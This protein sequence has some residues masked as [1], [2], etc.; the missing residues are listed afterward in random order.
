MESNAR[1]MTMLD[2][3]QPP[4]VPLDVLSTCA[5][6]QFGLTGKWSRL[7]GE[8]DLNYRIEDESGSRW[9]FRLCNANEDIA[10]F[11]CQVKALEHI[12][13]MDASLPVPK[14]RRTISNAL[15]GTVDHNGQ[16]Y[17]VI[18]LSFLAGA[19]IGTTRLPAETLYEVG[20]LIAR[21]GKALRGFSHGAP[22]SRHL[23]WDHRRLPDLLGHIDLLPA[24]EHGR[25]R[26]ILEGFCKDTLPQLDTLRNQ[27]IHSDAHP[28]NM[29]NDNG[30]VSGI[31]DFG[32]MV[33][34]TLVQDIANTIADFMFPGADNVQIIY[35]IVRGYNSITQLEEEE[36][37]LLLPVI[38]ARLLMT[39]LVFALRQ[40]GG[41]PEASYADVAGRAFPL[42]NDVEAKRDEIVKTIRRAGNF[43]PKSSQA[44]A[45]V[46][47][48]LKRRKA[49]MGNNLYMFYDTPIHL[50]KGEGVWLT[51]VDGKRYLDCYNNVPHVGHCHP[52]VTE[53]IH[54]QS[55]ILNTNTRY[56]SEHALEYAE[57]L[58]ATLDPSLTAVA[59]VNSG[60]EA[61]DI[62]W[63]M[64]KV[65][66]G[67]SGGLALE[68]A[69]HGITDAVDP[70][71]PS[72]DLAAWNF[73]HMR[74][75]PAPD[76]YRGPYKRGEN[77]IARRYADLADA[78]IAQLQQ[79]EY[80]V[81]A[82]MVDSAF[83]T[84]GMLEAPAGYLAQ[85]VDKIRAA[86]G[87]F[88][89]DEVQSGFGRMGTAMWGHQHH[90]VV[91]DFVTLG[92]PAGNGHPIGVV[93][94]RPEILDHF[95]RAATFFSTF[96]GNNVS[97]A[98][99]LAVLDVIRDEALVE[100]ART[101]GAYFKA[102]LRELKD[103]H[104]LI[105]DV[106]GTGLALGVELVH[107]HHTLEPAKAET[108]RLANMMRDRG[109]L[110]GTEGILGNILKLRPPAVFKPQ[111]VDIVIDAL[112]SAL[113]EL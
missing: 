64:A 101:T 33:F 84:N 77:D 9:V 3:L 31:I 5:A 67:R 10:I 75:I 21:L 54:R 63:R 109:V 18:L 13:R 110:I 95:T 99:G 53:A 74:T 62:A 20:R 108:K 69:Y 19:P 68:F 79:S 17:P 1:F 39:P 106:R 43:P 58:T 65:W 42:L 85:V 46:S 47:D 41:A 36:L 44:T 38:E 49:V 25:V 23:A 40:K 88:I 14:V 100:N 16:T 113:R 66:T 27:I 57:R 34:G 71:S 51:A 30:N 105:G 112:D 37:D 48:M 6:Q 97:C 89:A 83:M 28:D 56:L 2:N 22:A 93:I 60:S 91:P 35:E 61:N 52:Y 11:D 4:D 90:G 15:M 92:K 96:G 98:A 82:A 32:D 70:F 80:G 50:A 86:G 87:L 26:R 24:A 111:H 73:P 81:A 59:F 45:D 104:P 72:N 103:K 29:L 12:A 8:R 78:P 107:D 7:A 102:R 55:R 76:D 94:T